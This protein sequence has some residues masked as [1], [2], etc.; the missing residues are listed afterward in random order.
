VD[1]LEARGW[2]Q[3]T[4][5]EN[6]RRSQVLH[7]TP[8]GAE[9]ARKATGQILASEKQALSHLSLGEQTILIELLHKVACARQAAS[10]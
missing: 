8:R 9:L 2:V 3:R 5:S 1:R 4:Q 7:T 6:D 10:A